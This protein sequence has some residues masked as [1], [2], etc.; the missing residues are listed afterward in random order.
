MCVMLTKTQKRS[1]QRRQNFFID[2]NE[3]RI[4]LLFTALTT[5]SAFVQ[6]LIEKL[7][8]ITLKLRHAK[9]DK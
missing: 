2:Y 7:E 5:T 9:H 8:K 3:A 4:V 1:V 6:K